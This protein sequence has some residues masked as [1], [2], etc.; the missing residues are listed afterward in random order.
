MSL[1]LPANGRMGSDVEKT[2]RALAKVALRRWEG[3]RV[4]GWPRGER[5][6]E[7][8]G[9]MERLA[10]KNKGVLN[11]PISR[12]KG[13]NVVFDEIQLCPCYHQKDEN[14]KYISYASPRGY[15]ACL[16]AQVYKFP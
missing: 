1:L 3:F 4:K 15:V 12:E 7:V 16:K 10:E 13:K 6:G 5:S 9:E 11:N 2:S 14:G 8:Y